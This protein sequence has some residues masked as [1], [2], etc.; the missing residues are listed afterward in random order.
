MSSFLHHTVPVWQL[1]VL[2]TVY[3]VY[4]ELVK[5]AVKATYKRLRSEHERRTLLGK[6]P[7]ES[8]ELPAPA[9]VHGPLELDDQGL[10][11]DTRDRAGQPC[12]NSTVH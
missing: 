12:G 2:V 5:L 9:Q 4:K 1:L 7:D 6:S 11:P 3:V 10:D 8:P